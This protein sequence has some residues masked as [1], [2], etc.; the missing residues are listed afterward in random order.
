MNTCLD[1]KMPDPVFERFAGYI[2]SHCGI[3][4]PVTKK[5]ML[6]SRLRKRLRSLNLGSFEEYAELL[7]SGPGMC[8]ELLNMIDA[9]TTNKTDF[10]REA[11]HYHYLRDNVM[12]ELL[13]CRGAGLRRPVRVW[14]AGC[15]SGEEAYTLAMILDDFGSG[16]PGY[17][18]SVMGTDISNAVLEKARRGVYPE[19]SAEPVPGRFR[20]RYLM[21]SRNA[22]L[23][24]VRVVPEIRSRVSF[25]RLN[26]MERNFNLNG[27]FDVLF[28]RNVLIY[29]DKTTRET[30]L[31]KLCEH[32]EESGYLFL[33]HSET[34]QGFNLPITQ[35]RP[36]VYRRQ[37]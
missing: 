23:G 14:S 3:R 7:F 2:H 34:V 29:F 12:Q 11:D 32:L 26:L 5:G 30:L 35:I 25:H 8:P 1:L 15:S 6:E 27:G 10:F 16:T 20:K 22:G 4:M 31:R 36:A 28:C 33:G 13:D 17:R 37:A 24:L 19:K 21:R 18:Y 9:V